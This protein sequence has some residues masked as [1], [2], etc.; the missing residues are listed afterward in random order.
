MTPSVCAL[1][2]CKSKLE[3][4]YK[5]GIL[6]CVPPFQ[7][8]LCGHSGEIALNDAPIG[9]IRYT[10]GDLA[11]SAQRMAGALISRSIRGDRSFFL[12]TGNDLDRQNSVRR[13]GLCT[14]VIKNNLAN[15]CSCTYWWV[16]ILGDE[17]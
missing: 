16:S 8:A 13:H 3:E 4:E 10:R 9:N 5:Y 15:A 7:R 6:K 11:L 1:R 14:S 2:R 17:R 12:L